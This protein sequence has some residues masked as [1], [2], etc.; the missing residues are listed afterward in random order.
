[1]AQV[2]FKAILEKLKAQISSDFSARKKYHRG[3]KVRS[4]TCPL[5]LGGGLN[6]TSHFGAE[7]DELIYLV[8]VMLKE[9]IYIYIYPENPDPSLE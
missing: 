9:G 4:S 8:F 6:S 7:N 2:G 1:M 5:F 3:F